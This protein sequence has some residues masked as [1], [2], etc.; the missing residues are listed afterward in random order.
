MKTKPLITLS[1]VK[2]LLLRNCD[3]V[4]PETKLALAVI[5]QVFQDLSSS[6]AIKNDALRFFED[7]RSKLWCEFAGINPL[8]V[9]EIAIKGGFI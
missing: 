4:C 2:K 9:K 3:Y 8:F 7:D 1:S 5:E 6:G